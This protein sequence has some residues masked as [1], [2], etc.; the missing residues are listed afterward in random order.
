MRVCGINAVLALGE[1]RLILVTPCNHDTH[2]PINRKFS[3]SFGGCLSPLKCLAK[4]RNIQSYKPFKT[5]MDCFAFSCK[6]VECRIACP[7]LF[8]TFLFVWSW[9]LG[10][11]YQTFHF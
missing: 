11:S 2:K 7:L 8:V 3:L 9:L 1:T 10:L 6:A 5:L 4:I